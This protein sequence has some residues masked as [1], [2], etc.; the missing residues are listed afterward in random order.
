MVRDEQGFTFLEVIV[1]VLV[2]GLVAALGTPTLV[3]SLA[4]AELDA[5]AN[6]VAAALRNARSSAIASGRPAKVTISVN[7]DTVTVE[8]WELSTLDEILDPTNATLPEATVES[9]S[10][11][12]PMKH[13]MESARD[14][15][16]QFDQYTL[17]DAT[18][19]I[20]AT[21]AGNAYV[22]YSAL[23][24]PSAAGSVVL[25][26]GGRQAT[27]AVASPTG[28]ITVSL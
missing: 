26:T 13:P 5:A 16:I 22:E 2:L 23:G 3:G 17:L 21:F 7:L 12:V 15:V 18:D 25:R 4:Y 14:Y 27:I 28:I 1:V 8:R 6:E 19:I 10:A 9:A 11:F 24:E 20:S